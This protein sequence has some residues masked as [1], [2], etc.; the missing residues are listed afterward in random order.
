MSSKIPKTRS[1]RLRLV[2]RIYI[3]GIL[4]FVI[5]VVVGVAMVEMSHPAPTFVVNTVAFVTDTLQ[6]EADDRASLQATA[7]RIERSLHWSPSIYDTTGALVAFSGP[8]PLPYLEHPLAAERLAGTGSIPIVLPDGKPGQL[9]VSIPRPPVPPG[10]AAL[11]ILVLA[12]VGVS[13]WL[14]AQS[15]A[16]P[17]ARLAATANAFGAGNLSARVRM[18][19]SDELGE[20]AKAFDD[21]A[22]RVAKAIQAERELLANISHELRTPLQRIRIALDLAAEGDA[23]TA[24]ES[25]GEITEDLGDLEKLVDDVLA[26]TRLAL[27]EGA[28]NASAVPP[29][30]FERVDLRGLLEK[31]V[32]R[33]RSAHSDRELEASIPS[34][35][36]VISGDPRLLRRVFDNLLENARKYTD[37]ASLPVRLSS[38][39]VPSGI[40]IEIRDRGI[41][42]AAADLERVFEPFFRADR[43]R[44]R[45]T[46][47]LGLGLVLARR[48]VEAHGGKLV[49]VSE[50]GRGTTARVELP[51]ARKRSAFA[52]G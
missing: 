41:G 5:V 3:I 25:L 43:S 37:D 28:A 6:A 50:L 29:I 17:L 48:I 38:T 46:G 21:M 52:T 13:S 51:I 22:D 39:V 19:R 42:I 40:V 34:A 30:S 45:A 31:S 35:L 4:Q 10:I 32:G 12:V 26:A 7:N 20:V 14:T 47:G 16:V 9:V 11:A 2:E 33:F 8:R 1:L 18:A 49:L 24:R 27:Q 15:L 23:E 44:T 36:P